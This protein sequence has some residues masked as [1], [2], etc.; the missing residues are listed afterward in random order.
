MRRENSSSSRY[1]ILGNIPI[2]TVC[3]MEFPRSSQT[4]LVW[5]MITTRCAKYIPSISCISHWDRLRI[6][7]IMARRCSKDCISRMIS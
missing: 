3:S 4:I 6:M 5:E 1:R 7:Y 2:S